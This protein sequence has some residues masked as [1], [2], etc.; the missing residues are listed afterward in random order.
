MTRDIKKYL[1]AGLVRIAE[2][3]AQTAVEFEERNFI[4]PEP[5]DAKILRRILDYLAGL[6][7]YDCPQ[8]TEELKRGH[9]EVLK[10]YLEAMK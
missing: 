4:I 5:G 6:H 10:R 7:Q 8:F 2:L 1:K 3:E 9:E